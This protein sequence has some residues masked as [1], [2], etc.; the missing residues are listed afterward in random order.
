MS[1]KKHQGILFIILAGFF[2]AFMSFFVRLARDLPTMQKTFFR[3][4]G[5]AVISV[6][7]LL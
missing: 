7:M 4:A 3:K 5:A 2:F 6:G 1:V